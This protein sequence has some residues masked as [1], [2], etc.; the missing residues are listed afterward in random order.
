MSNA[1]TRAAP[2]AIAAAYILLLPLL[3]DAEEVAAGFPAGRIPVATDHRVAIEPNTWPWTSIGR[4]NVIEGLRTKYCTGTLI[5]SRHVLTAAHCVFNTRLATW[6]KFHDIHFVAG[7]SRDGTFRRHSVAVDIAADPNFR[8]AAEEGARPA[9][10]A[11]DMI[12]RDWAI[13]TLADDLDLKPLSW[14][15]FPSAN[16][17]AVGDTGEIARAGYSRDRPF[18]LSIHRGCS[19]RTDVPRPGIL[20]HRCESKPG[21]SGSPILLL[22]DVPVVIGIHTGVVGASQA[23]A[24]YSPGTGLGVSASVFAGAAQ[25]ALAKSP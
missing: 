15:A 10:V 6:V 12:S 8:P 22:K 11:P 25:T 14:H 13:I 5:G 18:F 4:V 16:L 7:Q 20:L 24:G 17:P 1:F 2:W 21:D 3:A 23:G 9:L 19:A